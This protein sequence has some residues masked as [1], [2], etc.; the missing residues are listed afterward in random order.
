MERQEF[1]GEKTKSPP[2]LGDLKKLR[3]IGPSLEDEVGGAK[4]P[5]GKMRW[6][7]ALADV[8]VSSALHLPS[9]SQEPRT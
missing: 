4:C 6:Q 3:G 7:V 1:S 9:P 8:H 2:E 5:A